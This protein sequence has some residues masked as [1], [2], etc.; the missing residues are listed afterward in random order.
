[1]A[2]ILKKYRSFFVLYGLFAAI[3]GAF[4]ILNS[5]EESHLILNQFF[6][7][8][9]HAFFVYSTYLGDGLSIV[10]SVIL[11]LFYRFKA[12]L[13]VALSG[14]TSGGTTQLLK[15]YAF[16]DVLRPSFHF[17]HYSE[18]SIQ[19]VP[20]LYMHIHNSFP[21]GHAT[22]AFSLFTSLMLI[23]NQ[24]KKGWFFFLLAATVAYSR[25]YLSQHFLVDILAGSF[26]GISFTLVVFY[27][28]EKVQVKRNP[29]WFSKSLLHL[30]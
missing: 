26:I 6:F 16:G 25:V 5:R 9:I 30:K 20:D 13:I 22:A 18:N 2:S 14:M 7:S 29:Y 1:M 19:L 23:S 21:S 15:N 17:E 12:A 27:L 10:A 11:L 24:P 28:V 8:E 4:L 3:S